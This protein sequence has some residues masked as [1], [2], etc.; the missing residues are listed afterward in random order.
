LQIVRGDLLELELGEPLDAVF[1]TATFHWIKDHERLFGRLR[2]ALRPGGRLVAQCGGEGNITKLRGRAA[3]VIA[4]D[5]YRERFADFEALWY[6]AGA[7]DT[8]E[9]LLRADFR[10]AECWLAPAPKDPEHPRE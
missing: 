4:R 7:T 2:A 9:R 8:R 10:S 6:Y 1:S 5:A 3:E